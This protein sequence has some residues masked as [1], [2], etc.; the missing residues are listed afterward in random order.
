MRA[1]SFILFLLCCFVPICTA[2]APILPFLLCIHSSVR[3]LLLWSRD[4]HTVCRI[5]N[6]KEKERARSLAHLQRDNITH[7]HMLCFPFFF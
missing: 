1:I 7:R 6:N 5:P 2:T 4:W 3:P